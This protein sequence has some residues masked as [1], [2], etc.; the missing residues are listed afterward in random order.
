[1]RLR[2]G[3]APALSRA[4]LAVGAVLAA[5]AIVLGVV[6]IPAQPTLASFTDAETAVSSPIKAGTL[7]SA[8]VVSCSTSG[9]RTQLTWTTTP[10]SI[11]ANATLIRFTDAVNGTFIDF[12]VAAS[13]QT[14][15]IRANAAAG[16]TTNRDYRVNVFSKL[17]TAPNWTSTSGAT[18]LF[19]KGQGNGNNTCT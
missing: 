9:N 16:F 1:M 19:H 17:S 15:Q 7:G 10:G 2:P 13:P 4:R 3:S 8:S 5:L 14:T 18:V 12:T 6:A 11:P